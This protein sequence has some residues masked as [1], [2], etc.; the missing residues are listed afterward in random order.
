ME[1]KY[2]EDIRPR[3]Q[4]GAAHHQ[5]R[6]LCQHLRTAATAS[7]HTLLLGVGGTINSPYGLE[8]LKESQ[9]RSSES[10]QA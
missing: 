10:Y 6:V 7:L 8:P 9:S 1:V 5:H 4:L 2:C 3:S